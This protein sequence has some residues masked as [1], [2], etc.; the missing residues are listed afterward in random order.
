MPAIRLL[1]LHGL[2]RSETYKS[3]LQMLRQHLLDQINTLSFD[4]L[5]VLLEETFPYISF[6]E[7]RIIPFT[8]MKKYPRIPLPFLLQLA[9][10]P[11]LY[12]ECPIE[13]KRQIWHVTDDLFRSEVFPFLHRYMDLYNFDAPAFEWGTHLNTKNT[14]SHSVAVTIDPR[15]RRQSNS[16]LQELMH[17][18]GADT[19]LY[20][21]TLHYCR[22]LF[23]NTH[24]VA[25]C[26]LRAELLMALHDQNLIDMAS[27]DPFYKVTWCLDACVREGKID[28]R[29]GRELGNLI[30]AMLESYQST[31]KET[32]SLQSSSTLTTAP[33]APPP[34]ADFALIVRDPWVL[35]LVLH[36][37]YTQLVS[38]S[39]CETKHKPKHDELLKLLTFLLDFAV[40]AVEL[41]KEALERG[42]E[43]SPSKTSRGGV[44]ARSQ[45]FD[46][47]LSKFY[48]S[49][50]KLMAA[51]QPNTPIT[52]LSEKFQSQVKQNPIA[53]KVTLYYFLT[54]IRA[55]DK[56]GVNTL[57]PLLLKIGEEIV[58]E[59]LEF[60]QSLASELA[61]L[62]EEALTTLIF[63]NLFIKLSRH[64]HIAAHTFT[65]RQILRL[66]LLTSHLTTR[67][68]ITRLQQLV[69]EASQ[70]TKEN[71]DY[72]KELK[73][74]YRYFI[75]R[76]NLRLNDRNA[77]FL[78]DFVAYL[79]NPTA[80]QQTPTQVQ[81]QSQSQSQSHPPEPSPRA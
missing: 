13:V 54:R 38:L 23:A 61:V 57:I 31:Q 48:P 67:E 76:M 69:P 30:E 74:W 36:E 29:R 63:E 8:I 78:F 33:S 16:I 19:S 55:K 62:R 66:L 39:Q 72:F 4:K 10:S 25:F 2:P 79:D 7:M 45:H 26:A 68:A 46:S 64:I 17:L 34:F 59:E 43:A 41:V 77:K 71:Y 22:T 14:S 24:N 27:S 11:E 81:I 42:D 44:P 49:L 73:P 65:H 58:A 37:V 12:H 35:S 53:R 50:L 70:L 51:N 80:T 56:E 5:Q 75:D 40:R 18:I 1:D 60:V 47:A 6:E 28:S 9:H 21:T 3:L 15:K 20:Y 52:S 32:V